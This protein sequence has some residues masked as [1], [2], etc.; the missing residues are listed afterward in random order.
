MADEQTQTATHTPG[1]CNVWPTHWAGGWGKFATPCNR[2]HLESE[3]CGTIAYIA[4][5]GTGE[6][7]DVYPTG[8]DYANAHLLSAAY[9]SY[10]RHCGPR[11]V[12]CAE[13]DLL[14]EALAACEAAACLMDNLSGGHWPS[15]S[16]TLCTMEAELDAV[17]AKAKGT[18]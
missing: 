15:C 10:D 4:H 11:A 2:I 1:P 6:G 13:A 17:I 7:N 18:P 14:G 12:A 16:C 3:A 5:H 8:I 9:T